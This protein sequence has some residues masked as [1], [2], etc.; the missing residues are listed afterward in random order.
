MGGRELLSRAP[1]GCLAVS[2]DHAPRRHSGEPR[3]RLVGYAVDG[4]CG[5]RHEECLLDGILGVGEV[6]EP[7]S[8]RSEN[9]W[10]EFSDQ[11]R[12]DVGHISGSGAPMTR[13]TSMGWRIGAPPTLGAADIC[14]AISSARAS[15]A[16]STI[17]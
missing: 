8:E 5:D 9:P 2:I 1:R 3:D 16:T 10:C 13:R 6:A 7:P 4:P 17:R 12:L 11:L 14:A 15:V